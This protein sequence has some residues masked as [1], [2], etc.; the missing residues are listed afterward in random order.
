MEMSGAVTH[1]GSFN[2]ALRRKSVCPCTRPAALTAWQGSFWEIREVLG[3]LL[4]SQPRGVLAERPFRLRSGRVKAVA[5]R[6]RRKG[7][8]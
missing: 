4:C 3:L 7:M 6:G 2:R 8:E 5:L 1:Q